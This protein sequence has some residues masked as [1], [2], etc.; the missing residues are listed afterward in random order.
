MILLNLIKFKKVFFLPILKL[1]QFTEMRVFLENKFIRIK[2]SEQFDD[3]EISWHFLTTI[4]GKYV[5]ISI[6]KYFDGEKK[7]K[8]NWKIENILTLI[9]TNRRKTDTKKY[10]TKIQDRL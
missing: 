7:L 1:F 5:L 6:V 9:L 3:F 10:K 4:N 8:N 2:R